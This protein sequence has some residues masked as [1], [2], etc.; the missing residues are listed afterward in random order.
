MAERARTDPNLHNQLDPRNSSMEESLFPTTEPLS[1]LP[2][3]TKVEAPELSGN[4][5]LNRSA[6]ALGRGMG[7]AVAGVK[8]LPRQFDR[9]RSSIHL[10]RD[11]DASEYLTSSGEVAGK[12]RD[13]V[14]S[15]VAEAA[16]TARKYQS[17]MSEAASRQVQELRNR[18]VRRYFAARRNLRH[19][20]EKISRLSFEEPLRF[21]A[22]CAG[23][24]F[25]LGVAL[26]VWRSNHE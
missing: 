20:L 10:V 16:E 22:G 4:P 12:W 19:R 23:A 21:V 25:M 13:A 14:E 8:N 18:S 5:H 3:A 17:I 9:L 7:N 24:A 11:T 15:G 6:Q 1:E 26:R 2:K